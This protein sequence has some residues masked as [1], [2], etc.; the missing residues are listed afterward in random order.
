M[1]KT[2]LPPETFSTHNNLYSCTE[3]EDFTLLSL[4]SYKKGTVDFIKI[5]KKSVS[6][7]VSVVVLSLIIF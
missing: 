2:F 4:G 7:K 5:S 1:W 6:H 3:A